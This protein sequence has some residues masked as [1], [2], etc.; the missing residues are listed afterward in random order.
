[1][2]RRRRKRCANNSNLFWRVL[3]SRFRI[4]APAAS[5]Y[6]RSGSGRQRRQPERVHAGRRG[7]GPCRVVRSAPGYHRPGTGAQ[8][9]GAIG[10]LL[11]SRGQR[12]TLP[13][14][15]PPGSYLPA[16]TAAHG[17]VAK[18]QRTVAVLPLMN[19]TTDNAAGYFCDG[20]AE[21]LIDLLARTE[22]YVWSRGHRASDSRAC[23]RTFAR[24][25]GGSARS[26]DRG[27][28]A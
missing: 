28:R 2:A 20:L 15:L 22:G 3:V 9:A 16:F 26:A 12:R 5:V 23:R 13:D 21:E 25:V 10:G 4:P 17:A 6:G 14:R 7:A 1:M 8:A 27:R 18:S 19:L 24:S 11:R